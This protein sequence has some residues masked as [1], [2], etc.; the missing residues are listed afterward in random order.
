MLRAPAPSLSR[1][2]MVLDNR[3]AILALA[4]LLSALASRC[5]QP[6]AFHWLPYFL[7]KS[8][9]RHRLPYL[10]LQL[11]PEENEGESLSVDDVEGAALFFEY[12]VLGVRT[13]IVGTGD[14]VGF[15]SVVAP[16]GRRAPLAAAATK[17]MME[18]GA[19]VVLATFE[20]AGESDRRAGM[21]GTPDM[22][23]ASRK[24]NVG[25]MLNLQ[26]TMDA[27]LATMGKSTRF[28]LRYY[29][30]RLEKQMPLEYVANAASLL[31]DTDLQ[32]LNAASLNPVDAR[33]FRRRVDVASTL[34]DSF[35]T[36]LRGP[37]GQWLSLAGGW[38]Q[39]GTTVLHWQMNRAGMEKHS[40][41]TVMRS[42]LLEDEI[43]RGAS[44]LL[45]FGGTPHSMR[46]AFAQEPVSDLI[47]QRQGFRAKVTCAAAR[48]FSRHG[49]RLGRAN[50]LAELLSNP[51][52]CWIETPEPMRPTNAIAAAVARTHRAA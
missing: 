17:A 41:G 48:W 31:Q 11:R 8:V 22:I 9:M 16:V 38:R 19:T 28:N 2:L 3:E 20:C 45:I 27:T 34:P 12:R 43:A 5:E 1:N 39:D 6:G 36:G 40:I 25:R 44:R 23:W 47:L 50:F 30:R 51:S 35:I 52:L 26:S 10:V 29:R 24:R 15:S 21:A 18:R 32:A 33:E 13:G 46:H 49:S 14:A 7:D 4:P 37:D 42:Y